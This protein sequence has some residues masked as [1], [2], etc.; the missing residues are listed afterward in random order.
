M[1]QVEIIGK[2]S[3]ERRG[4]LVGFLKRFNKISAA[5]F[6]TAGIVLENPTLLGL[7]AI[8]VAQSYGLGRYEKWRDRRKAQ[9]G[10]GKIAIAGA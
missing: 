3:A 10:L 1:S 7:A 8:D 5:V 2:S 9:K 6:A 4:G